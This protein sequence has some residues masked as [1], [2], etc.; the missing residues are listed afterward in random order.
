MIVQQEQDDDT[1]P[2]LEDGDAPAWETPTIYVIAGGKLSIRAALQSYTP[3]TPVTPNMDKSQ[4]RFISRWDNA[5]IFSVI[6][7]FDQDGQLEILQI[8]NIDARGGVY[9]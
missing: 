1:E 2:D 4:E 9:K 6:F 7:R 5:H 8:I 3:P